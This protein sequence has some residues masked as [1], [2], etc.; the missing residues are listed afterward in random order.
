MSTKTLCEIIIIK[1]KRVLVNILLPDPPRHI[2]FNFQEILF[3]DTFVYYFTKIIII[4]TIT[5]KRL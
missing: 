3:C 2:L 4:I 5:L 1:E